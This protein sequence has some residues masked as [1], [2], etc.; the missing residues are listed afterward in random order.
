VLSCFRVQRCEKVK[1]QKQN[2]TFGNCA[3]FPEIFRC[4]QGFQDFQLRIGFGKKA[5]STFLEKKHFSNHQ[6]VPPRST[7]HEAKIWTSV[8]KNGYFFFSDFAFW[9]IMRDFWK[10]KTYSWKL[11]YSSLVGAGQFSLFFSCKTP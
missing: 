9:T 11:P 7:L 6:A 10:K 3:T 8:A 5:F 4:F 2:D 1:N